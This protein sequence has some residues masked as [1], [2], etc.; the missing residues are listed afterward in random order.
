[1]TDLD[2]ETAGVAEVQ[3][4][5]A[6]GATS[7]ADLVTGYLAR[8]DA[9]DRRGPAVHAIRC[10]AP[11]AADQAERLDVERAQGRVR[12]PL[13][14]VPVLVKDNIDVAGL[15]DDRPARSPWSTRCP[16][17]DA[18]PGGPAARG[19]R[20]DPGQD[21]PHRD[22][23]LHGRADAERVLLARRSGPQPLR[24]EPDALRV[25]QR[26][27]CGRCA[28]AGDGHRRHRD[29]RLDPV[30][31]RCAEPGRAEARASAWSAGTASCRS[32]PARTAPGRCAARSPTRPPCWTR[33]AGRAVRGAAASGCAATARLAVPPPPDD[34]HAADRELFDA[35]LPVMR[36]LGADHRRG[37]GAAGDRRDA[38]AALRVRPRPGRLPRAAAGRRAGR[39]RWP[40]SS[41][42][43]TRIAD[44][45]LKYGQAH[46]LA[47]LEVDHEADAAAYRANR[48]RDLAV[49]GEHGIDATL[50]AAGCGRGRH[51]RPGT[52][53]GS[54]REPATRASSSRP[55][56]GALA[57]GRSGSRS[58][59]RPGRRRCCSAWATPTSRRPG[60]GVRSPW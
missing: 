35:A 28:R 14:G 31:E 51:A 24:R 32:P 46:V 22:G 45:A 53:P 4:A 23:Q 58:S 29:R 12:G 1:M 34:L 57:A 38:G 43:T 41:P 40:S 48:A 50:R 39:A 25:E 18:G 9:L 42:G 20:G 56:T 6:A 17:R 47:A 36:D 5:M 7:S 44:V 13:H 55:A 10:L 52:V 8:I 11:D 60:P 15:P 30:P 33:C 19:R 27:R 16:D 54:P 3:A 21:E 49:A 26:V 59:G 37:A 2:L